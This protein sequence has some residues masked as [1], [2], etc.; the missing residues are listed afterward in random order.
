MIYKFHT[1]WNNFLFGV[2][3]FKTH[4]QALAEWR[5]ITLQFAFWGVILTWKKE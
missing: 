3:W 5:Y 2:S 4:D 1:S